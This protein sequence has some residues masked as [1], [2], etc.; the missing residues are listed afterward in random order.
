MM[1][2]GTI[3]R[4]VARRF[5]ATISAIVLG[6]ISL[7]VIIDFVEQ[8][9][10]F[11]DR[12]DFTGW[13]S[14]KLAGMHTP[15]IIEQLMPFIL[16]FGTIICLLS[17]SRRFEL[18]VAR[19]S[20][21]SVWRFLSAPLVIAVLVGIASSTLLNPLATRLTND[22]EELEAGL[23]SSKSRHDDTGIWFRQS[24]QNGS[25]IMHAAGASKR[26]PVLSG[27]RVFVFDHNGRFSEKIDADRAVYQNKSWRLESALIAAKG[28]P[29][30]SVDTFI[31]PTR[32]SRK[33]IRDS[34]TLPE[35]LSFWDLPDFIDTA[36]QT[37][38][39]TDRFLQA[40]HQHLARPIFLVAMVI[41]AA[42]VSLRLTRYGG[43][44]KLVLTGIAAGFLLYVVTEVIS[45]LGGNGILSPALSAWAPGI[46]ALTFGA[47]VL[48]YQE[49]G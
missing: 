48:L 38:V 33:D 32:L 13:T 49:D 25:S 20:G 6:V 5:L 8:F 19:A 31:L 36:R 27:V 16:L 12:P 45:D 3:N 34:L 35:N 1:L 17:L 40:Y 29:P 46:I 15:A 26:G 43:T 24:S 14:M 9:R 41:I 22:A 39:N 21:L 4:Y 44:G 42:T 37:G 28:E 47:T 23:R 30:L 7:I 11:G 18:V 2:F 10:K